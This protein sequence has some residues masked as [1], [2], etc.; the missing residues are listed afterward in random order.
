MKYA[1]ED[2]Q[3]ELEA[4]LTHGLGLLLS[5]ISIYFLFYLM[6]ADTDSLMIL[7]C[8]I[9]AI[10]LI[11]VYATSTMSHMYLFESINILL[12]RCDQGFIYLLIV[13]TATPFMSI[14]LSSPQT[15]IVAR[16]LYI[17]ILLWGLAVIGCISKIA[18]GHRLHNVAIS[19]YVLL[20][21]GEAMALLF[22]RSEIE[23]SALGWLI[24]GGCFYTIG[25]VFLV[26]DWQ[27]YHFHTIWHLLVMA[28]SLSHFTSIMLLVT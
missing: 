25:V 9:Y 5:A 7:G 12:R 22:V 8:R 10:T 28:G 24:A 13:G 14:M 21:W 2:Q 6:P 26:L 1:L 19:L 4:S 20:G 18:F 3:M 27:K 17:C 15:D 23:R 16:G 11:L